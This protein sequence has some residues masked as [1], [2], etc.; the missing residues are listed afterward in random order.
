[1]M[2]S[3]EDKVKDI[4]S[5]LGSLKALRQP[6]E[7]LMDECIEYG[8]HSRRKI[9]ATKQ[10]GEKTGQTIYDS[11][12]AQALQLLGDGLHGN[13]FN[14]GWLKLTLPLPVEFPM[15]SIMR[16]YNG[17]R[18]D[19]LPQV[20]EWLSDSQDVVLAAIDRSNFY[21]LTP[22][23]FKNCACIGTVMI[24][25][26]KAIE[27]DKI[28]FSVPHIREIF[29]GRDQYGQVDTRIREYDITL[30]AAKAKFGEAKMI[31]VM[32]GFKNSYEKNPHSNIKIIHAVYPRED[33]NPISLRSDQMPIAS[34]WIY[35]KKI[36]LESGFPKK[37]FI[38]WDW[39]KNDDE[40]YARSA[41]ANAIN[42]IIMAQS[43]GKS[44]IMGGARL[45]DPPYVMM[46]TLRGRNF[47]G[48]GGRTYLRNNEQAP[49]PL[50]TGLRGLPV[51]LEF[52]DRVSKIIDRWLYTPIFLMMN[53]AMMENHNLREVQVYEMIGERT[54][55]I[56]PLTD[57][58]ERGFLD[59]I[60]DMVFDYEVEA[61][62]IPPAPDI[63]LEIAAQ[64]NIKI[65]TD[66]QGQ[67]SLAR[68]RYSK[69]QGI[70]A[71][72][73]DI[74]MLGQ[75]KPDVFDIPDVDGLARDALKDSIS[76]ERIKDERVVEQVRMERAQQAMEANALQVAQGMADAVPKLSK[77]VEK[78]SPL[79]A[80]VGGE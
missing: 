12:A 26:E 19:E 5:L 22:S 39:M 75:I 78:G 55:I 50:D 53:N 15:V 6:F 32:P 62:R 34:C 21:Q 44:N 1:M 58:V 79:S 25:S 73:Q 68:K 67:L 71:A 30:K 10:G 8:F 9:T 72:V 27:D 20:S 63:L 46:E 45:A 80:M 65:K 56:S 2:K 69:T 40:Y 57:N 17:K 37:R 41:V 28:Y 31:E 35:N 33:Y 48:P 52:Q 42:D 3:D 29:I 64:T 49:S 54:M 43:M 24:D 36:L 14:P 66:F 38:S 16:Q 61:K 59:P 51:A 77:P 7:S 4:T 13:M 76:P 18:I 47:M 23:I 11:T 60:I 74:L 70:R